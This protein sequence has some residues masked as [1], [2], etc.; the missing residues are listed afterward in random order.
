M[1]ATLL[2]PSVDKALVTAGTIIDKGGNAELNVWSDSYVSDASAPLEA[3]ST[4][5][6]KELPQGAIIKAIEIDHEAFGSSVTIKVGDGE[7]DDRYFAAASIAAVGKLGPLMLYAGVGYQIG[8]IAED[9]YLILTTA[10]AT[11]AASKGLKI[12]VYYV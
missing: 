2:E 11:M 4:I 7:D 8:T 10:G 1:A 6:T 3:A 9:N 5:K 12:K